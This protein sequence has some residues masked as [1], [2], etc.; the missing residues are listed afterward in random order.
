MLVHCQVNK[1]TSLFTFLFR[2][3]HEGMD[4]ADAYKHVTTRR[5]PDPHWVEF[6]QI[7]RARHQIDFAR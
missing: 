4:P 2:V 1:R 7:V 5:I 6:V 3:V